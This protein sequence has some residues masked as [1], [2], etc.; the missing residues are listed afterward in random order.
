VIRRAAT[1]ATLA[2]CASL[3]TFAKSALADPQWDVGLTSGVAGLGRPGSFWSNTAYYGSIR[4]NLI[5]GRSSEHD[6]GV[7]PALEVATTNFD[8]LRLLGG[9]TA[10]LPLGDL[11]AVSATPSVYVRAHDD[12]TS[13]GVSGRLFLGFKSYNYESAYAMGAGL[14]LGFD[15]DLGGSK[16]HA[17]VVAVQLDALI[18]AL[19]FALVYQLIR[20]PTR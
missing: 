10:V 11:F 2:A 17:A 4:G 18:V 19:P 6:V 8:D 9:A 12:T 13:P 3:A 20:G 16:E 5:F 15:Q 1:Y 14:L 7:G